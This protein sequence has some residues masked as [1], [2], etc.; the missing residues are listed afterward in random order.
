MISLKN[1][2]RGLFYFISLLPPAAFALVWFTLV[3]ADKGSADMKGLGVVLGLAVSIL[4]LLPFSITVGAAGL[5]VIAMVKARG[6]PI[7]GPVLA[8][9]LAFSPCIYCFCFILWLAMSGS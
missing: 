5:G 4:F 8:T 1:T 7:T 2:S 9:L 3:D 6:E